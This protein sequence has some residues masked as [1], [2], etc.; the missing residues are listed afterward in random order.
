LI[1]SFGDKATEHLYHGRKSKEIRKYPKD[2]IKTALRKLD[3]L[4]GAQ[5]LKDLRSP[6]GNQLESLK[7]ILKGFFSIRVNS[8]WRIIFQW[9]SKQA[10]EVKLTDYH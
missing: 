5:D 10:K 1:T 2:I 8:Q 3:M 9:E 4:N 7:G 6:P